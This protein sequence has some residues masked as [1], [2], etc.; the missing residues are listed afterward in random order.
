MSRRKQAVTYG[1]VSE[2]EG[3]D[4]LN[5][6]YIEQT[7]SRH[8][9]EGY[10]VGVISEGTQGF[11][12][13]G[14]EHLAPQNTIIL[15]NADEIHTGY[16][17]T[18]HGWSYRALYPLPQLFEQISQD[19]GKP[20]YGAPYFRQ[21]VVRDDQLAA[22]FRQLFDTLD[23]STDPLYRETLIYTALTQL[24]VRQ[25]CSRMAVKPARGSDKSL[26][27]VKEFLD[28][29]SNWQITLT[30]LAAL[31]CMTP[32]SLVRAFKR[33]FGLPPHAYQIQARLRLARR[34]L[35]QGRSIQDAAIEAGFHDQ[36]HFHRHFKSAMGITPGRYMKHV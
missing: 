34:L 17:A 33:K 27:M 18:D 24:V 32:Y 3:L 2:I 14:A 13:N 21:S 12:H 9:H 4:Y 31:A 26:S 7:F 16:A 19:L 25:G 10:C 23:H 36:S 28:E 1:Q 8:A 20:E 15:V 5:A 11:Y 6:S 22:H 29:Y 30:E 35:K